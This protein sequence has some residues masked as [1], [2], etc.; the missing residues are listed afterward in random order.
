MKTPTRSKQSTNTIRALVVDD[1][2]LARRRICRLLES[3]SG[4]EVVGEAANGREAL[5]A[6]KKLKPDLMFLDVQMPVY[7]GFET[8]RQLDPKETPEIVFV[9]A[10]DQYALG[11]FDVNAVD[12]LLKPFDQE[13]F[14]E[15]LKRVK[16]RINSNSKNTANANQS[17]QA[18]RESI[19]DLSHEA[20]SAVGSR[21]TD[22]LAIRDGSKIT[23][24]KLSDI[25][26]ISAAQNYVKIHTSK[27]EL[28]M[29]S[30]LK[31]LEARLNPDQF[32]RI[33]R[34]TLVN[35]DAIKEISPWFHGDQIVLLHSG[36]KLTLARTRRSA[37]ARLL[38]S[39]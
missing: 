11:A 13:R 38:D 4:I 36:A 7:D 10:Y 20:D 16:K 39:L 26:W 18:L 31:E 24:V 17:L 15:A 9:T 29:R 25:H 27:K 1:E 12:Y 14:R 22:R 23:F 35:I 34:S 33:H 30:S 37:L 6:L 32:I 28:L 19:S 3:E 5:K 8:L 21:I 2:I